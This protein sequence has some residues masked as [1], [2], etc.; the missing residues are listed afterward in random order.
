MATRDD[1]LRSAL[2]LPPDERQKLIHDLAVSM[3]DEPPE[4]PSQVAA[5]WQAEIARR[6]DEVL[7]GRAKTVDARA[8]VHEAIDDMKSRLGRK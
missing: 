6:A 2:E 5:A 8:V 4:E 3:E 1:I 7:T